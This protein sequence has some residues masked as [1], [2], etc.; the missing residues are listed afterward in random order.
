MRSDFF[1]SFVRYWIGVGRSMAS[2]FKALRAGVVYLQVRNESKKE[3]TE[4]YP[5]PVSARSSE[6]LPARTRGRLRNDIL[7][8]T[9]CGECVTACPTECIEIVTE[10]GPKLG[11]K[12]ISTFNVDHSK[13]IFCG[14]CV[15]SCQPQSLVHE[16]AHQTSSTNLR[17]HVAHYGRGPVSPLLRE[18]WEKQKE[19]SEQGEYP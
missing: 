12:W 11:K 18:L 5:D 13:C 9:G 8:C 16:R 7:K 15:E 2:V 10:D 6:E 4:Q 1:A 17:E 3:V 14:L 19:Q